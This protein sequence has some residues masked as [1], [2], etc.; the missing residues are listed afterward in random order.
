MRSFDFVVVRIL[1]N[2]L[3]LL[4]DVFFSEIEIANRRKKI[5]KIT[6]IQM[7]FFRKKGKIMKKYEP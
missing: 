7:N 6:E 3:F 1:E 5:T 4:K 2:I